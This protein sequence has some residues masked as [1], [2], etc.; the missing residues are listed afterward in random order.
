MGILG[1]PAEKAYAVKTILPGPD[2]LYIGGAFSKV[3][4]LSRVKTAKLGYDGTVDRPFKTPGTNGAVMDLVW[5]TDGQTIFAGGAFSAFSKEPRQ[6][7]ARSD[8]A[9]GAVTPWSV[10]AGQI[11]V[12]GGA[13]QGQTCGTF[14]VTATRLFAGCGRGPN[15]AGAFRLETAHGGSRTWQYS[16]SGN[17]QTIRVLPNGQLVPRSADTWASTATTRSTA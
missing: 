16:T 7:I 17:V 9:T 11:P 1:G 13:K 3:D 14:D 4:G 15:F 5:V 10:P 8:P 12:G 2:A 6:S